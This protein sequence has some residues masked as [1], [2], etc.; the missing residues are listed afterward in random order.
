M[1]TKKY[2]DRG[3]K[4]DRPT[5]HNRGPKV[6]LNAMVKLSIEQHPRH[7]AADLSTAE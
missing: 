4:T 1:Y 7:Q 2:Q 6:V 3:N 5:C